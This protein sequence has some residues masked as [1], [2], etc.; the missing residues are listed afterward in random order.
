[1]KQLER[2]LL[3]QGQRCFFCAAPIPEGEASVEHLAALSNGGPKEDA[4]CVVCCKALNAAVGN[5]SFKE[6]LRVV[7][8]QRAAFSCP[9]SV[10]TPAVGAS[11]A[12]RESDSS[13]FLAVVEN[14]KKRGSKRPV[15]LATLKN[16]LAASFAHAGES[17]LELVLERL[18]EE[19]YVLVSGP[20]VSYP[21]FNA[22]V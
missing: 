4:N 19:K 16:A 17:A 18:Q 7:L 9:M 1:M 20:K 2:L 6:K 14:L 11:P 12:P 10:R 21:S 22:G 5:L 3:H 8:A 13:L 15:K